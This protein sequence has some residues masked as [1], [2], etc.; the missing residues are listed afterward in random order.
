MENVDNFHYLG[1]IISTDNSCEKD[2]LSRMCLAQASFNQLYTC[3]FSREDVS[4]STK[5]RVY[6]ASVR[7]VLLYSCE[8]WIITSSLSSILDSCEMRFLRRILGIRGFPY[9]PNEEVRSRCHVEET[10]SQINKKRRLMWLGHV[11]RIKDDRMPQQVLLDRHPSNWKR[12]RGR[13]CQ[14]WD[15]MV[16]TETR[17]LTDH[18]RNAVGSV[19]DWSVD[20]RQWISYLSNL[21]SSPCQ[22][23]Q[24]VCEMSRSS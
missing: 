7:S 8:S 23:R 15:R 16:H 12:P 4:I 2:I 9:P 18:I 3:L 24:L 13:P 19:A 5:M 17:F 10:I 22:S 20:G 21:A 6:V 1:S 11:L 14:S